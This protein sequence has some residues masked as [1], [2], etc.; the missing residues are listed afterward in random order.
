MRIVASPALKN[1]KVAVNIDSSPARNAFI[2]AG[3]DLCRRGLGETVHPGRDGRNGYRPAP[4]LFR[5]ME[6]M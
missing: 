1:T 5:G 2:R 6:G 4:I 3:T